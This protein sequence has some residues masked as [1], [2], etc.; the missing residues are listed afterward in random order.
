MSPRG[1][2]I[3]Q[4][5]RI[6]ADVAVAAITVVVF[7]ARVADAAFNDCTASHER[8]CQSGRIP[9]IRRVAPDLRARYQSV[10]GT[11]SC[12]SFHS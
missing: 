4:A 12:R 6:R 9:K 10:W 11:P 5:S 8:G 3:L 7:G 2:L 1:A